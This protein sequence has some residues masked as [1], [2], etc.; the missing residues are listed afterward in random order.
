MK[1]FLVKAATLILCFALLPTE[2]IFASAAEKVSEPPRY[3]RELSRLVA[4][5]ASEDDFGEIRLTLGESEMEVDGEKQEISEDGDIAPFVDEEGVLQIPEEAVAGAE[6]PDESGLLT[7]EALEAQGYEVQID[8]ESGTVSITEPY[9]L[10]R[11]IVKTEDGKVKDNFGATHEIRVSN[12]R[13]VLQYADKA[14]TAQ[15]A[16]RFAQ[17]EKVLFCEPDSICFAS[18]VEADREYKCWGSTAAGADQFMATLP[19]RLPQVTVAVIDTGVDLD[20]PFLEGR[21]LDNGWDFAQDDD[22]P[23]DDHYHGTHCAGI[24]RDATSENVK[25]LPVKVLDS[26]GAGANSVIAEGITYAAD[27][28]ADILSMSFGGSSW[29]S[30]SD[31]IDY[32]TEKGVIAVAAAG[33][34][35]QSLDKYPT[36]PACCDGVITV[37]A[38]DQTDYP[39]YYSNYGSCIDIAAPGSNI[40]SSVPDGKFETYSGTSMACPLVAGCAA[41]LKSEDSSRTK[42]EILT[43]LSQNA[44]DTVTPG[45]D[46][47]TGAGIVYLGA[48]RAVEAIHFQF[49]ELTLD[50][51]D[52]HVSAVQ[53]EPKYPSNCVLC[54]TADDPDVVEIRGNGTIIALKSGTTKVHADHAESGLSA[55]ITVTVA[56]D[57][58]RRFAQIVPDDYGTYF[59]QNNGTGYLDGERPASGVGRYLRSSDWQPV[60]LFASS[61]ADLITDI[62]RIEGRKVIRSDGTL[63]LQNIQNFRTFVTPVQA[64]FA[65][66]TPVTGVKQALDTYLLTED[67]SVWLQEYRNAPYYTPLMTEDGVPLTNVKKCIK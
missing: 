24:V 20:H 13:T 8:H 67:G 32:A 5:T 46:E 43:V 62:A 28:G 9:N 16:E 36:Y 29:K 42:D 35:T 48:Y 52:S 12:N 6:A 14:A 66:G 39:A 1:R 4:A 25:I 30:L 7:E 64:L 53:F 45:R 15:A 41:L 63:W 57:G 11:L 21:I 50:P 58:K 61:D 51:W 18:S 26:F 55:E 65:D 54:F 31:A 2:I 22:D 10:C 19:R 60:R 40:I 17:E 34:D 37:A 23:D 59:V 47:K 56:G 27:C 33:N 3:M 44:R 38:T 49:S